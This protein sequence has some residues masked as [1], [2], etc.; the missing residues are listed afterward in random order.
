MTAICNKKNSQS[1]QQGF[2]L[3]EVI[4]AI[5]LIAIA[6]PALL[7]SMAEVSNKVADANRDSMAQWVA[8]NQLEI[9]KLEYRLTEKLLKGE[10]SGE[11]EMGGQRWSWS[12]VS[13][14]S[15]LPGMWR[16]TA[17]A[18]LGDQDPMSVVGFIRAAEEAN[19]RN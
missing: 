15:E 1:I 6:L 7:F 8:Y 10:S 3:L 11:A 12:V 2:T 17:S 14:Q 16:V 4:I 5:G 13:E 19:Q 9:V 18:G